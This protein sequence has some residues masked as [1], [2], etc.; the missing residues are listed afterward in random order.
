[1]GSWTWRRRALLHPDLR[2]ATAGY[3]PV[4]SFRPWWERA[5]ASDPLSRAQY[6]DFHTWLPE[7]VLT[8]SDR[9]TMAASLEAREPLLDYRLVELAATIPPDWKLHAGVGKWILRRAI[10]PHL[11]PETAARAKQGFA[12]P[13]ERWVRGQLDAQGDRFA[14]PRSVDAAALAAAVA[15]HRSGQRDHSELLYSMRVLSAFEKRWLG[16]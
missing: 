14:A 11:P 16:A 8:K 7:Y 1:M 15:R 13:L 6:V 4:E 3:D 2:A 9:A 12:P 5:P 10:A